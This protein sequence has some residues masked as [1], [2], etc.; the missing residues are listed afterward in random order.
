MY[1]VAAA[2]SDELRALAVRQYQLQTPRLPIVVQCAGPAGQGRRL[3]CIYRLRQK[4]GEAPVGDKRHAGSF[5]LGMSFE[6]LLQCGRQP[7]VGEYKRVAAAVKRTGGGRQS[8]PLRSV[9]D[10]DM[11]PNW[12]F[13]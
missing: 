3:S 4:L 7:T 6:L 11:F 5:A 8:D 10:D 12:K 13:T 9:G 1:L 2:H